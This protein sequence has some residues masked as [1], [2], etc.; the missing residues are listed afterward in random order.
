MPAPKDPKKREKWKENISKGRKGIGLNNHYGFKRGHTPWNKNTKGLMPNSINKGKK[1]EEVYDLDKVM[2]IKKK[3]R[4]EKIGKKREEKS[5]RKGIETRRKNNKIWHTQKT[6]EKI[7]ESEKGKIVSDVIKRKLSK[8]K[9]G[10][11]RKP[12]SKK[13]IQKMKENRSNQILPLKDSS[14]EVKIQNFLKKLRIEFFTHQYIKIPHGYQCDIL[15]PAMNLVI[16]CDGDFIHCNPAKYPPN[17]VRYPNSKSNQPA[18]VIWER[19]K[20]R[21]KELIEKGFKV[22]RL[23]GSEIKEMNI[24]IFQNK[25]MEVQKCLRYHV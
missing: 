8:A 10:V 15:I 23:W 7:S 4:K 5:I 9:I 18:Y 3:M 2:D 6:K 1:L 16:E 17:F 19:D 11:K 21:T 25:L 20:I 24:N 13:T 22:L 12:F 14:I